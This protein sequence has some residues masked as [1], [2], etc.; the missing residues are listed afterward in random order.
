VT[1]L[2]IWADSNFIPNGNVP[3]E[4]GVTHGVAAGR[5]RAPLA[6][7]G[8]SKSELLLGYVQFLHP[9]MKRPKAH[10]LEALVSIVAA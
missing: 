5:E 6:E 4:R 1:R 8:V 9:R 10:A 3:G 2:G 7:V